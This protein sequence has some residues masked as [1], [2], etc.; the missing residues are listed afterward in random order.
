MQQTIWTPIKPYI[1]EKGVYQGQCAEILMFTNPA[2]INDLHREIVQNGSCE[3][4]CAKHIIWLFEQAENCIHNQQCRICQKRLAEYFS[5]KYSEKKKI[6]VFS[7]DYIFCTQCMKNHYK[8]NELVGYFQFKWSNIE[9]ISDNKL[10][11]KKI[12]KFFRKIFAL[13][14]RLN[15]QI[16]FN[17][18]KNRTI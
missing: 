16:A 11:Q 10:D 18:F 8:F 13:P 14:K 7:E 4:E 1:F 3:E 12:I 5:V 6:P 9:M 15:T 2:Q 17:F